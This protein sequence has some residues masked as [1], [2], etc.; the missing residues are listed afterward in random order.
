LLELKKLNSSYV[1]KKVKSYLV[2]IKT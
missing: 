2:D 1:A